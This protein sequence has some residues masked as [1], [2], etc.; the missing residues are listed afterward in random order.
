M[1]Y[2]FFSSAQCCTLANAR[3]DR[4]TAAAALEFTRLRK[5][6]PHTF[7]HEFLEYTLGEYKLGEKVDSSITR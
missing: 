3:V 4:R 2:T 5:L 6:Y 1:N 7:T